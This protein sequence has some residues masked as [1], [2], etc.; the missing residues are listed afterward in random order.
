MLRLLYLAAVLALVTACSDGGPCGDIVGT[1]SV[2]F[3]ERSGSCGDVS[4]QIVVLDSRQ[5][6]SAAAN[7]SGNQSQSQDKCTITSDIA[8]TVP[9]EPGVRVEYRGKVEWDSDGD[10]AEGLMQVTIIEYG[11]TTCTGTYDVTYRRR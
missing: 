8:C 6:S 3:D 2:T 1:Y 10:E 11:R 7:C 4:E 5:P 9:N